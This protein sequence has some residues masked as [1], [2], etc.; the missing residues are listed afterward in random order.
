MDKGQGIQTNGSTV[1]MLIV[2]HLGSVVGLST[3]SLVDVVGSFY[4]VLHIV[5]C[6]S[7]I[8]FRLCAA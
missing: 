8:I 7:Q 5:V 6:L 4:Q 1:A 2:E 3:L